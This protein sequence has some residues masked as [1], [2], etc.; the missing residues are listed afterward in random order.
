[1]KTKE[2]NAFENFTGARAKIELSLS[3]LYREA[4]SNMAIPHVALVAESLNASLPST[5]NCHAERQC[6]LPVRRRPSILEKPLRQMT[7]RP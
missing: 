7:D 5:N 1:M 6:V 2:I 4:G 3:R